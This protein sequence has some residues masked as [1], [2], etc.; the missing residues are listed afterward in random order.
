MNGYGGVLKF[1]LAP[2]MAQEKKLRSF[3]ESQACKTKNR[4]HPEFNF[5]SWVSSF[6]RANGTQMNAENADF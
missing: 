3:K 6:L 5:F 4:T 2:R 1:N